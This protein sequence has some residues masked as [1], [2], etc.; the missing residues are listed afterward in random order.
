MHAFLTR[1]GARRWAWLATWLFCLSTLMPSL[2]AWAESSRAAGNW[3]EVCSSQ[4]A[5][6]VQPGPSQDPE[7]APAQHVK[8]GHCPFCLLQDH[9]PLVPAAE[10]VVAVV[11]LPPAGFFP[12]L[13]LRSPRT[14]HAWSPAAARAPPASV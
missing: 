3:L 8:A 6:W 9:V 13:F 5:R 11:A 2:M 14:L 4:G 7:R 1:T 10:P 12:P